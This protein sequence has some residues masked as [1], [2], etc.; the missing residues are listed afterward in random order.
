MKRVFGLVGYACNGKS[1]IIKQII[2][3]KDYC[4]IDLPDLYKNEAYKRGYAGVTEWYTAVGLEKYAEVSKKVLLDYIEKEMPRNRNLIIDD[5][6][7]IDVYNKL[8]K[9]F[10]QMKLISFHSK[11]TD[12]LKR[13]EMRTGITDN[14][15][16][17]K[18][19]SERDDMKR[20][21]GIEEIFPKCKYEINNKQDLA[22][23]KKIFNSQIKQNQI[24]CIVGYSGS[25]KSTV[26]YYLGKKLNIPVFKYGEAV[27][28]IMND[29]GYEKI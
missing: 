11:Y 22:F 29:N 12:R 6:F 16:L 15:E 24:I 19:L 1:T 25:G 21:C 28:K 7:D 3:N 18:G 20:F 5:I 13:L 14:K 4:F 9:V 10:P 8:I 23:A 27:T 17:I 26:S 2:N